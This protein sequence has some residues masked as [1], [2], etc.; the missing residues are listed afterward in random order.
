MLTAKTLKTWNESR[1]FYENPPVGMTKA[2]KLLDLYVAAKMCLDE[3][4]DMSATVARLTGL[5]I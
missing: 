5:P 3:G 1:A 2:M 4:H